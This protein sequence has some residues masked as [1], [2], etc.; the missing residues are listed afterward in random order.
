MPPAVCAVGL[1][2][3]GRRI[4]LVPSGTLGLSSVQQHWPESH[5]NLTLGVKSLEHCALGPCWSQRQEV[6]GVGVDSPAMASA[7]CADYQPCVSTGL[8]CPGTG[9]H[10]VRCS[11]QGPSVSAAV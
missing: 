8:V 1:S 9:T 10:C 4:L 2:E 3:L 11:E 6:P 5:R 7:L